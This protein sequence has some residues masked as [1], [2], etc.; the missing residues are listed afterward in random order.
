MWTLK[1]TLLFILKSID[2][3]A[4]QY[5]WKKKPKAALGLIGQV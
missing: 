3:E 5:E 2:I 4:Y 1:M